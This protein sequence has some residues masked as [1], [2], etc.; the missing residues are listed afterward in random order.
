MTV[1]LMIG[2]FLVLLLAGIPVVWAM[3]AATLLA[4]TTSG[5][6]LPLS[7]LASQTLHGADSITLSAIPLFLLAGGIMNEGGLTRRIVGVA[8]SLFGRLRGG[9]GLANVATC[10]V[11]GGI[12]GSA[13]ADT[14]AVASIMIPAMHAR[15]YPLAFAAAVT[16][17]S[18]TLGIIVPPSVI[19]ILYGVI[20]NTSIGGLFVAG[21]VPGLLVSAAFMLVSYGVGVRHGFPRLEQRLTMR[22]FMAETGAAG[23]A[24]LMPL[25]IL[26]SIVGGLATATEAAGLAV[27]YA[28]LVGALV[29]RELKP[30]HLIGIA[31][32]ALATTGAIMMVM[33]VATP[34]A[35][36]LTVE[37]IPMLAASW[38]TG[39]HVGPALTMMLVLGLLKVV[40]F[41]LDLGPALVI[42]GPIL[43]PIARA[44]GFGEYQIGLLFIV[45]LGIGLFTPPIGTNIFVVCNVAR[46][47]MWAVSR[48]LAPYWAASVACVVLLAMVA[49]LT[50]WLPHFFGL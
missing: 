50:E 3:A 24:L 31:R 33:A 44:A 1:A 35:W 11:Y 26:G 18:G 29:Y 27:I 14:G 47:D 19:I 49:P 4:I 43:H 7:W 32:D 8:E 42:L 10:L 20:T 38:I 5:L 16:A 48:W 2:T 15:G 25:L 9:L 30:G 6:H 39:L 22:R 41:W 23:P 12:S 46:V 21:I 40:G 34:F 17:A 37:R 28:L 13:T 45:T 36:V